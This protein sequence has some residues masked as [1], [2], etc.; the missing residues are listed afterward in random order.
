MDALVALVETS[1]SAVEFP[2]GMEA[3]LGVSVQCGAGVLSPPRPPVPSSPPVV[4]PPPVRVV[5]HPDATEMRP[6][7][8][9]DTYRSSPIGSEIVKQALVALVTVP[10][11]DTVL[12]MASSF[13]REN[14]M[15]SDCVGALA[16]V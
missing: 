11:P 2:D 5:S 9:T 3:G 16:G 4:P 14:T 12:M 7:C 10:L 13:G 8:E 6:D 15:A 1:V